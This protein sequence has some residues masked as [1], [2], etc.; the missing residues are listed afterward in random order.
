[1]KNILLFEEFKP[2]HPKR[3]SPIVMKE[4]FK[5]MEDHLSYWFK[6]ELK[7][8][9]EDIQQE[10]RA[11]SVWFNDKQFMYKLSYTESD[12]LSDIEKVENVLMIIKIYDY[13]T[14]KLLKE[15]QMKIDLS[16][17]NSEYLESRL[18]MMRKRILRVPKSKDDV[19]DFNVKQTRRLG[20]NI[21]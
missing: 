14:N 20:D 19:D 17:L 21:Y 15:T 4:F 11:I 13:K 16:H 7:Y 8:D 6:Y 9:L 5:E 3:L 10:K 18:K 2:E 12:V 1:M